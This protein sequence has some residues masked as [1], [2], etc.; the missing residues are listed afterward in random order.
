MNIQGIESVISLLTL[1]IAYVIACTVAGSFKAWVA[2][3]FGDD[4]AESLGLLTLNPLA[5]ADFMGGILLLVYGFGWGRHVPIN[6]HKIDGRFR[7][8]KI[9][10][11]Y[12]SDTLAHLVMGSIAFVALI[13]YFGFN[14][15][16]LAIPMIYTGR[17][18][19]SQF[20]NAYPQASSIAITLGLIGIALI[21]LNVLLAVLDFIMSAFSL[22]SV[23]LLEGSEV[24]GKYRTILMIIIPMLMIFFFINPLRIFVMRLLFVVGQFLAGMFGGM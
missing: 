5:H 22:I 6:P 17:L 18:L 10:I 8:L 7:I 14:V 11:A 23:T 24:Y 20:M 2:H 13:Y 19:Q 4:T 15:L 12:L 21:F 9:T 16:N 1:V 3:S